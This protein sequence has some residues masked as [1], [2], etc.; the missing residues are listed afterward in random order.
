MVIT[1]A[2]PAIHAT[3]MTPTANMTNIMAQLPPALEAVSGI[4]LKRVL[5]KLAD[6]VGGKSDEEKRKG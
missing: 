1:A 5:E 2:R 4:D 3:F 6:K